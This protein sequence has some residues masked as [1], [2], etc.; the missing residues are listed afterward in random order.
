PE[1]ATS[2]E[3]KGGRS[4]SRADSGPVALEPREQAFGARPPG[5]RISAAS[6]RV[7]ES[8]ELLVPRRE[9][10]RVVE[11]VDDLDGAEQ[12]FLGLGP[13]AP[14]RKHEAHVPP[15]R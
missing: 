8:G 2:S 14:P 7:I 12:L 3:V 1:Q 13:I 6:L 5:R 9:G 11:P 10:V 4:R 15:R